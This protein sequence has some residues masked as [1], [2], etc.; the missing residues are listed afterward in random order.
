MTLLASGGAQLIGNVVSSV[1]QSV[2]LGD[3]DVVV[4]LVAAAVGGHLASKI[5]IGAVIAP[6]WKRLVLSI[7][8]PPL[9]AKANQN[10]IVCT[11]ISVPLHAMHSEGH[12]CGTQRRARRQAKEAGVFVW[13]KVYQ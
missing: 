4:H 8:R 1:G 11:T 6:N 12:K 7:A 3:V 13:A 9:F 2:G 5:A 10:P